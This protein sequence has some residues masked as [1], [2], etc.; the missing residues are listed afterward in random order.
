VHVFNSGHGQD[1]AIGRM[2]KNGPQRFSTF[3]PVAI[4]AIG[5]LPLPLQHRPIIIHT[6]RAP[7]DAGLKRLDL[8]DADQLENFSNIYRRIDQWSR[9]CELDPNPSIPKALHN[10]RADNWRIL[11]SIADVCDWGVWPE[12]PRS[13]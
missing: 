6:E 5:T 8:K 9:L 11:L 4:S 1:G 7:R 10:R 13:P 2:E 3:A 12:K